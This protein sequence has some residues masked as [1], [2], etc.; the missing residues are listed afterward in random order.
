MFSPTTALGRGNTA[1][2]EAGNPY[3][4]KGDVVVQLEQQPGSRGLRLFKVELDA[5]NSAGKASV[6]TRHAP[7]SAS[8]KRRHM[9]QA[10]GAHEPPQH[11]AVSQDRR[12][13]R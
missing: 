8:K 9:A 3:L 4:R 2:F 1:M 7:H 5:R 11:G 13:R 10:T 12:Q 6:N